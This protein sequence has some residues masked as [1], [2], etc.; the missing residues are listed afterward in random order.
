MFDRVVPRK[1]LCSF[2]VVLALWLPTAAW[3][4]NVKKSHP[5]PIAVL[6]DLSGGEETLGQPAMNGFLLAL[7]EAPFDQQSLVFTTLHD[8]LTDPKVT[9]LAAHTVASSVAIAAGFTDNDSVLL[10]G[11]VFQ[12]AHVPFLSIG[13]TDPTLPHVIGDNVFLTPF[14]DNAQA[15]AAAEFAYGKF[16]TTVAVLWDTSSEYT[17]SLASY[18]RTRF[19]GLGGTLP[20]DLA[21]N[22]GCNLSAFAEQVTNAHPAFIYLAALPNCVGELVASLRSQGI[23]LPL[24]GGDGLDTPNL[25]LGSGGKTDNVFYTTHAWLSPD[26][27]TQEAKQFIEAY[28]QA[29]GAAPEDAFAA[30]GY[31]AANLILDVLQRAKQERSTPRL[32]AAFEDTQEFHGVT[33]TIGFSKDNHVPKKTVWIIAVSDGQKELADAFI[34]QVVP[35]PM[36]APSQSAGKQ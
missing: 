5:A 16:G 23:D 35:D 25:W 8:T 31:D 32:L 34:P 17:R 28:T 4:E 14:G 26:T 20:V 11:P 19:L 22:G 18:F 9:L 12:K 7:Q 2:L 30:L 3:G 15:A 24:I 10:A 1:A 33:G 29:Y 6:L 13:A 21:Y 36:I 27:G